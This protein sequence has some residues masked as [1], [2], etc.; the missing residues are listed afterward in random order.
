MTNGFSRFKKNE[1]GATAIE[2]GLLMLLVGVAGIFAFSLVGGN[3]N[4]EF[5][6]VATQLQ[7]GDNTANSDNLNQLNSLITALNSQTPN[8]PMSQYPSCTGS[9]ASAFQALSPADQSAV[10]SAANAV[11][12]SQHSS[13]LL[14]PSA[15]NFIR[16]NDL[17]AYGIN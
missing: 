12:T 9:C 17:P 10:I 7:A 5:S 4:A 6:Y 2:Y 15:T 13:S 3:A 14:S 8:N 16:S 11:E 1:S